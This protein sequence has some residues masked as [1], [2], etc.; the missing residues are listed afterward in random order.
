MLFIVR[1]SDCMN[2]QQRMLTIFLHLLNGKKITKRELMEEFDKKE[3]TIQRDIGYIE[4][5]LL[6]K[7]ANASLPNTVKIKRDGRGSYQ[8][9]HIEDINNHERLTDIDILVL[10]KILNSTRIFSKKE[11]FNLS[12]KLLAIAEDKE[13]LQLFIRNEQLYYQGIASDD[14]M[15]R[16][17]MIVN[18]ITN[19]RMLSFFYTKNGTTEKFER[20]PNAIYFSD[21][22]FYMLSSSHTAQDDT[23]LIALN[24][25]RVH[26]MDD[27]K[28]I[29]SHNKRNHRD[30]FEGGIF[31]TQTVLPFFGNPITVLLDFYY[32]PMYVLDRFPNSK[33]LQTNEDGSSK[34]EIKA[35]DGY[36]MK[37]WLS[38]QSH[39][40]KV[41]S[42]KHLRDYLIQDMKDTL[43]LY[44]IEIKSVEE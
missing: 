11:F 13:S 38:S 17:E 7:V 9:Q 18:A 21:M 6:N 4:E 33:I 29:S 37:M 3:S 20:V 5:V 34:I 39:M 36:G 30:K 22:Y 2:S 25:F 42:P 26:S 23:D 44:G 32:D 19:N 35:N 15:E 12:N 16:L 14:M 40:V 28:V 24:K 10:L 8:L 1:G 27:V 43:K 41:I 31:R